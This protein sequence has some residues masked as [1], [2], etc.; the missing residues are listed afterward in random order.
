M[1]SNLATMYSISLRKRTRIQQTQLAARLNNRNGEP[2]G[3]LVKAPDRS[4][5]RRRTRLNSCCSNGTNQAPICPRKRCCKTLER[6]DGQE[7][8]ALQ[9]VEM[10]G[11]KGGALPDFHVG[12]I[13]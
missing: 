4:T 10:R 5:N 1:R 11:K 3:L 8:R 6:P 12:S 9:I 2:A 7:T 13:A